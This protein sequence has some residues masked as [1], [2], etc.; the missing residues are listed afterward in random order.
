MFSA[1][2][3]R[4]AYSVSDKCSTRTKRDLAKEADKDVMAETHTQAKC[5]LDRLEHVAVV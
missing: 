1:E 3:V 5:E 2:A 4:R